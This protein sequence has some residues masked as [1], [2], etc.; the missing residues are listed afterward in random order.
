MFA[1]LGK[2][3]AHIQVCTRPLLRGVSQ[4]LD[5][6]RLAEIFEEYQGMVDLFLLCVDRDCET[7]RRAGLDERESWARETHQRVLIAE[8]AWQELE[9]WV[10]AGLDLP[11]DWVWTAVR[12]ECDPKEV[13]FAPVAAQ[14]DMVDTPGAGRK[15]L[16]AEAA[17]RYP[18]I[19][20]LCPEDIAVLETRLRDWLEGAYQP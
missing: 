11:Q 3:N 13:Y 10:L 2:P 17:R 7:G 15:L 18:R 4:A 14:R 9:V 8:N 20:Q 12:A 19:K 5:K 16:A 1:A 6:D